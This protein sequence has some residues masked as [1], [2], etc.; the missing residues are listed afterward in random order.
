[1]WNIFS[2]K[3]RF[4]LVSTKMI[5]DLKGLHYLQHY[6]SNPLSF[7]FSKRVVGLEQMKGYLLHSEIKRKASF[8][9]IQVFLDQVTCFCQVKRAQ[10]VVFVLYMNHCLSVWISWRV[11]QY[12]C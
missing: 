1:V 5:R 12:H 6:Q 10:Y 8:C 2:V 11:H 9:P 3:K 7:S 4:S